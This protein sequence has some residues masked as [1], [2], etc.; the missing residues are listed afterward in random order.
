[1]HLVLRHKLLSDR[2]LISRR[3]I[4]HVK[5]L[6]PRPDLLF[7]MPV[8]FDAP[9]HPQAVLLPNQ[10]H[11]VDAAVAR[12][13]ANPFLHVNAV[14][15]E[16]EIRSVMHAIPT[17]RFPSHPTFANRTQN[18]RIS[19]DLRMASHA[20]FSRRNSRRAT[21]FHRGMTIPAIN[22]KP[23]IVMFM[24]EWDRLIESQSFSRHIRRPPNRPHTGRSQRECEQHRRDHHTGKMIRSSSEYLTFVFH[25][26]PEALN[27][28]RSGKYI[29]QNTDIISEA[30]AKRRDGKRV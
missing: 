29:G 7:G 18:F 2:L 23:G 5:N 4:L 30:F 1:V 16:N 3:A 6:V 15:K 26:S 11:L 25:S 10:R 20:R 28:I 24:T 8:A 13:A 12:A 17:K 14:V 27:Q 9:L 21:R 22:S 19:P